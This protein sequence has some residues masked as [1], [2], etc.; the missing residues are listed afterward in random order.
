MKT[1]INNFLQKFSDK[2]CICQNT[3]FKRFMDTS[4]FLTSDRLSFESINL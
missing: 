1:T 3:S 2:S 4:M